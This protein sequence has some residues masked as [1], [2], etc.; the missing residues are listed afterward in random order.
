MQAL[1]YNAPRSSRLKGNLVVSWLEGENTRKPLDFSVH[2][3]QFNSSKFF[4]SLSVG[5]L[6]AKFPVCFQVVGLSNVLYKLGKKSF[7][8]GV[9]Y[10]ELGLFERIY[11]SKESY[12]FRKGVKDYKI[13]KNQRFVRY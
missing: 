10:T 13:W 1:L 3:S 12:E 2:D 7:L 6:L 11:R 5:S 4:I 8:W 9:I